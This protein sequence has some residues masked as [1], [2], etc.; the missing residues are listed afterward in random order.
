MN[1]HQSFKQCSILTPDI[2]KQP[3]TS[4]E[5][6]YFKRQIKAWLWFTTRGCYVHKHEYNFWEHPENVRFLQFFSLKILMVSDK[7]IHK[8]FRIH[9]TINK[10]SFVERG[11]NEEFIATPPPPQEK[12]RGKKS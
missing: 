1:F 7:I 6:I 3:Q 2:R 8:A 12:K 4:L 5:S 9:K 10:I 11:M